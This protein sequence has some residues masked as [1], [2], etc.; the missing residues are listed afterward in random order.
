MKVLEKGLTRLSQRWL[1]QE[2]AD[3]FQLPLLS[4]PVQLAANAFLQLAR[5]QRGKS[6]R[7]RSLPPHLWLAARE[8]A[9]QFCLQT[10]AQ[11]IGLEAGP[12]AVEPSLVQLYD[13]FLQQVRTYLEMPAPELSVM[14]PNM[15]PSERL[16]Y[17]Q[18]LW[19][20]AHAALE[21]CQKWQRALSQHEMPEDGTRRSTRGDFCAS[22]EAKPQPYARKQRAAAR[23]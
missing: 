5:Y 22:G 9:C 17:E 10:L 3:A 2:I 8:E 21:L 13:A 11:L 14:E 23:R 1:A 12:D 19:R 20:A 18:S 4:A 15:S 16:R 6:E 7:V